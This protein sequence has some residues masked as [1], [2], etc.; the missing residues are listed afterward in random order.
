MRPHALL[1]AASLVLPS[2]PALAQNEWWW[3][4]GKCSE[5]NYDPG[6]TYAQNLKGR[7]GECAAQIF[8]RWGS[9]TAEGRRVLMTQTGRAKYEEAKGKATEWLAWDLGRFYDSQAK[10]VAVISAAGSPVDLNRAGAQHR[11]RLGENVRKQAVNWTKQKLDYAKQAAGCERR[12]QDQAEESAQEQTQRAAENADPP[13]DQGGG[14]GGDTSAPPSNSEPPP[15]SDPPPTETEPPVSDS[16]N[17]GGAASTVTDASTNADTSTTAS[18]EPEGPRP[19]PGVR[20]VDFDELR[21]QAL[22]PNATILPGKNEYGGVNQVSV[23]AEPDGFTRTTRI[24]AP[25]DAQNR[26]RVMETKTERI[27]LG[28]EGYSVDSEHRKGSEV[29]DRSRLTAIR[30]LTQ[31]GDQGDSLLTERLDPKDPSRTRSSTLVQTV[32][33]RD[34]NQRQEVT[35]TEGRRTGRRLFQTNARENIVSESEWKG[36]RWQPVGQWAPNSRVSELIAANR[37]DPGTLT[38]PV[39]PPAAAPRPARSGSTTTAANPQSSPLLS[40]S[41]AT[42]ASQNSR[43]GSGARAPILA[44]A[45]GIG[46]GIALATL[47]G[48]D[49]D[50]KKKPMSV[51]SY[52]DPATGLNGTVTVYRDNKGRITSQKRHVEGYDSAGDFITKDQTLDARGNVTQ[53]T[54]ITKHADGSIENA[55]FEKGDCTE[56]AQGVASPN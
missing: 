5:I 39:T 27:L 3:S 31:N 15:V 32:T 41:A 46:G 42:P 16:T 49:N 55:F 48:R 53:C 4:G 9:D 25:P 13:V 2:T 12:A 50:D 1:L 54:K 21:R 38:A 33:D 23:K 37:T 17:T 52:K 45:G 18:T 6:E 35:T 30:Q 40:P 36:G 44:A 47:T 51:T 19:L 7:L 8:D 26:D 29:L 10:R 43:R 20:P 34:G 28:P 24:L 22:E 56:R 14:T 11:Q